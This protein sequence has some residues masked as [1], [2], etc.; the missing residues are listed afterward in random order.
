MNSPGMAHAPSEPSSSR[1]GWRL[2]SLAVFVFVLLGT[3]L[4]MLPQKAADAAEHADE[5][6]PLSISMEGY[7]YP[8]PVSFL[9][10]TVEGTDARMGYM[11]VQPSQYDV[12]PN[13][14]TVVLMHGYNFFGSYWEDTIEA[15]A[16]EGYRVVVPDHLGFGKSA[17]PDIQYDLHQ[18]A[19]NIQK[20][21][22]HLE[23]EEAHIVGHSLGGTIAIRFALRFPGITNKLVLEGPIGLEDYRKKVPYAPPE[24]LYQSMLNPTEEGIRQYH[25]TYYTE[26]KEEYDEF[27]QV[28]YRWSLSGEYNRLVWA[29]ALNATMTYLEPVKYELPLLEPETLIVIG[30]ED[31]TFIGRGV[32]PE[33]VAE[34]MGRFPELA[35]EAREAIPDA[36]VRSFEGVGHLPHVVIPEQFNRTLIDF[37]QE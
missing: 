35:R 15:L 30:E 18:H 3:L 8:H 2:L 26:W 10:L 12:E 24:V 23:I 19:G 37:L 28:H 14:E 13:G 6:E 33:E 7:E 25:R 5:P 36:E 32:V 11:D 21:L 34:T 16:R 20:L 4:P 31:R 1:F 9:T 17:K 27:V 29:R 22:D